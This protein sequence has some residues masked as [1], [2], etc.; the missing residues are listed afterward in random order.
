MLLPI[1]E[2]RDHFG[3]DA[4]RDRYVDEPKKKSND[5]KIVDNKKTIC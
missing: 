4:I 2:E 1:G 3:Y 5:T